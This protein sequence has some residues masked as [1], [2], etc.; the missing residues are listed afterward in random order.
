MMM[1]NTKTTKADSGRK[2][3]QATRDRHGPGYLATIGAKGGVRSGEVRK[4]QALSRQVADL[5]QRAD[6]LLAKITEMRQQADE[7]GLPKEPKP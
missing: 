4:A 6:A 1:Q 2:G 7:D 5:Q 3:G